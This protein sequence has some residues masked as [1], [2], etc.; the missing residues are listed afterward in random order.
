MK[1]QLS[2]A[3]IPVLFILILN[4]SC[5]K[6]KSSL[7]E[8]PPMPEIP[9]PLPANS[10]E[11]GNPDDFPEVKMDFPIAEGPFHPTWESIAENY[12]GAPD[13]LREAKFGIWVHFGAQSAGQSGDWYAKRLYMQNGRFK[14]HYENHLRDFGHPSETGYKDILRDWNPAKLDPASLTKIYHDAGARFLLLQGVHHDN[15][16]NWNSKYQPWNVVNLGPH[17]DLLKEWTVA[18][19]KEGMRYG[20]TF[21]HEYTWWWYQPA[22]GSDKTAPKAGIPYDANLTLE[23]GKG[24]WWEGYDPRLLYTINLNEYK[25]LD[26]EFA[27]AKGIFTRHLEYAKWYATWWALRI[28]DVVEN[29][30]PDFIYTDGNSTQP[31]SGLKSGTGFKCDAMQRVIAD[32]Y[33]R[34]LAKRGEVNTFSV[35][36]FSPPRSGIVSTQEGSVP[37]NIKTDQ[38]WFAEVAMGDWFYGPNFTYDAGSVI[39]YLVEN[40]SRDGAFAL[41]VSLLPDGS[42]DKGSQQ[43]LKNIGD[44]MKR[45]GEA[46]YGSKAWKKFGE[47]DTINGQIKVVPRGN[48]AQKHA[49]FTF[50]SRDF[51]FTVGKNNSLYAF[52]MIVPEAGEKLTIKSLGKEAE[53]FE[54]PIAEVSLLGCDSPLEWEQTNDGLEIICPEETE[55]NIAL[56]FRIR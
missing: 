21:H 51:R 44:W 48:F 1:L 3:F 38:P 52:C 42:L 10:V 4:Y 18:A 13:W 16:D 12:P 6:N 5:Q 17:R 46:V 14:N 22:F 34:T 19:R 24:K 54:N 28:M 9:E 37:Q 33:N 2:K 35:V 11:M 49:D 56:V 43:M 31:F 39:R 29:Y 55:Y 47:G 25:G 40:I 41:C 50:N 30:D 26:V 15:F 23:D 27:P 8:L 20:V 53:L 45:N 32:Y 7:P 36:K